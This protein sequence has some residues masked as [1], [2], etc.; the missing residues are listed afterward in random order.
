MRKRKGITLDMVAGVILAV[1]GVGV[2]LSMSSGL[3]GGPFNDLYC[4]AYQG[5]TFMLS[6]GSEAPPPKQCRKA[7]VNCDTKVMKLEDS[8]KVSLRM[9]SSITECWDKYKN[10]GNTTRCCGGYNIKD[11]EGEINESSLTSLLE[12]KEFCP[13]DIQNSEFEMMSGEGCGEH[14]E[15][16]FEFE[17]IKKGDYVILRYI[18]RSVVVR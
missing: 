16:K 15:L 7:E 18:N 17:S 3:V 5:V 2:L 12:E 1:I 11:M 14:N 10:Y 13:I 8:R 9:I 6:G 4:S